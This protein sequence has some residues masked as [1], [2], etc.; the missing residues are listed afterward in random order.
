MR[1]RYVLHSP[2]VPS[3]QNVCALLS[4]HNVL[5]IFF[6]SIHVLFRFVSR[7]YVAGIAVKLVLRSLCQATLT[8]C[9]C[10]ESYVVLCFY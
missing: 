3:A 5:F 7:V 8:V 9:Y 6:F 2:R 10:L 4:Q 1:Y